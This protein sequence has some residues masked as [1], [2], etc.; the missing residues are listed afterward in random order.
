MTPPRCEYCG[1]YF[2]TLRAVNHHI[3]ASKSCLRDWRNDLFRKEDQ[4]PSPSPKRQK[5][6]L[7]TGFQGELDGNL[8]PF[9]ISIG[10]GDDFV[11]PSPPR[12]T[13]VEEDDR[14]GGG[15]S[16]YRTSETERFIESYPGE[17][18]KALRKSET[19]FDVWL[20]NQKDEE[21]IPWFPF[22]SEQEWDLTKWLLKNVG[23]KSIDEFLKLPI[24]SKPSVPFPYDRSTH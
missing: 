12:G 6:E 2:K 16:T 8:D 9:E 13:S 24:V 7:L 14:N 11:M 3:S 19:Q 23:Q 10:L 18:G 22:A 21:K 5:K 15:E 20:K 1:K 17:P 4:S